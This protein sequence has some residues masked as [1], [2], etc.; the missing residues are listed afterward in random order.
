MIL[1]KRFYFD[2]AHE[3]KY[4]KGKCKNLHGHTYTLDVE[5]EG[6]IN[7]TTGMVMDLEELTNLVNLVLKEYDHTNITNLSL[8]MRLEPTCENL[9]RHISMGIRKQLPQGIT[10]KELKLQE[11]KGGWARW[12]KQ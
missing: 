12:I 5:I 2:A 3:L 8:D 4:H 9:I 11:G 10:L 7:P 6:N 1:G